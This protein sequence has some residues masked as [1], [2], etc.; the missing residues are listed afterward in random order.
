[1]LTTAPWRFGLLAI[2]VWRVLRC[3]PRRP[4]LLPPQVRRCYA[5]DKLGLA[6][7]ASAAGALRRAWHSWWLCACALEGEIA[8]D[9][10]DRLRAALTSELEQNAKL[11]ERLTN[12]E[13]APSSADEPR[14]KDGRPNLGRA[15]AARAPSR[16][17]GAPTE[18]APPE[19]ALVPET[20]RGGGLVFNSESEWQSREREMRDTR[21]QLAVARAHIEQLEKV[22]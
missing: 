2:F 7:D 1:M 9:E 16:A 8:S 3:S 18:P 20:A 10:A 13:L 4:R 15:G 12:L 22:A 5:T 21:R 17:P 6:L 19:T 14:P 11:Q